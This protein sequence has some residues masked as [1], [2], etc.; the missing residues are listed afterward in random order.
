MGGGAEAKTAGWEGS[1][2]PTLRGKG[3]GSCE[4]R[5]QGEQGA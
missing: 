2:D 1:G 3:T 4:D 5:A